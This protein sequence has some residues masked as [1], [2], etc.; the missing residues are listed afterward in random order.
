[1]E[2]KKSW[3]SNALKYYRSVASTFTFSIALE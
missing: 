1:M 3:S 2:N